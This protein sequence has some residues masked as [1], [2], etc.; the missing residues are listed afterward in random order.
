MSRKALCAAV[1]I[2][3]V[4]A[5]TAYAAVK[6]QGIDGAVS[7]TDA[8]TRTKPRNVTMT[9]TLTTPAPPAGKQFATDE[10]KISL[11]RGMRFNGSKFA[12]CTA[13]RLQDMGPSG[14]PAGSK[15]GS[16][17]ADAYALDG[18]IRQTL[19]V[20]AFNAAKGRKLLLLVRG[21]S[22]VQINS[23]IEA[24]LKPTT[25]ASY[26]YILD[27]KLPANLKSIAG[28]QPTLTKFVTRIRATKLVSGRKLGYVQSTSCPR[29]GWKFKAD[30]R[31]TDGDT[32]VATDKV[33]CTR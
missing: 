1:A 30:L 22:P 23:V 14:C 26:G 24:T 6:D 5:P 13:A 31:F 25:S 3:A 16:G 7:P 17:S 11:P 19:T 8:G 28:A 4:A 27:V 9:V 20:T 10:A 12:S 32:G 2:A 15:V 29:G 21:T 18:R 33:T